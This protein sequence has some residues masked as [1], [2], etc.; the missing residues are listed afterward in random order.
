M[1]HAAVSLGGPDRCDLQAP[2][3]EL[4]YAGPSHVCSLSSG[5]GG[6]AWKATDGQCVAYQ[7]KD[8][9]TVIERMMMRLT[10]LIV[11]GQT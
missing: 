7:V 9:I 6:Q 1:P 4:T 11:L 3:Q 5:R 10:Y 2:N 8:E